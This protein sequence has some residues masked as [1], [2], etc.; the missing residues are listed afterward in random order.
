MQFEPAAIA[1]SDLSGD[2]LWLVF[3]GGRILVSDD[4][5]HGL[6]PLLHDVS[7][8]G[9]DAEARHF[10]GR[11]EGRGVFAVSVPES[12][13][14][15]AGWRFD[16]LRRLLGL[17]S[18]AEFSLAGRAFQVLEWERNHRYCGRCGTLTQS[19]PLGER[20]RVCPSCRL[21]SYPRI[22][23][24]VIV[25]VTRGDEILLARA[26]RFTRPMFSTLAGFMEAGESAEETLHREVLEEVGVRVTNLRYFGSQS[27]P[28]P[29]N[30]MLGFH[31]EY[32][33]GELRLQ[34]EEIAEA[35]FFRFDALPPTPPRGSIA[36]ALIQ[37]FVERCRAR[38]A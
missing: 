36:H 37:D 7:W 16:D 12:A 33:G 32:A 21:S 38:H 5:E 19:H 26:Q 9:M 27:W 25:A 35:G 18:D 13:V 31:A 15:P 8:F 14:A 2:L 6:F 17:A 11:L 22:N 28:F 30:L 23:P 20:A 10:L 29:N 3:Q 4:A 1:P 34:E 24:C